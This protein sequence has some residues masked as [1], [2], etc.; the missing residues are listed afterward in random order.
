M[1]ALRQKADMVVLINK[2]S[3]ALLIRCQELAASVC[4]CVS[5]RL[6]QGGAWDSELTYSLNAKSGFVCSGPIG[7]LQ[8]CAGRLFGDR[9]RL[10]GHPD[11][12]NAIMH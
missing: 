12:P 1:P 7:G 11:C 10:H 6:L 4:F 3:L 8:T 5:G 9:L 2:L